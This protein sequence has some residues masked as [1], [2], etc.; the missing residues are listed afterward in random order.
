[1]IDKCYLLKAGK[2]VFSIALQ[3]NI[4]FDRDVVVKVTNT[5]IDQKDWVFGNLQ[6]KFLNL[7]LG[8]AAGKDMSSYVDKT[9]GELSLRFLDL[10]KLN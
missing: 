2:K 10:K 3:E 1:M 6:I 8:S 4:T 7:T 9:H 5:L